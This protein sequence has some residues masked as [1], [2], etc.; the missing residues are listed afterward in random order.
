[1][2]C[3]III[4]KTGLCS[5]VKRGALKET[6]NGKVLEE[7]L[8]LGSIEGSLPRLQEAGSQE[9]VILSP[10]KGVGWQQHKADVITWIII[11]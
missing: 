11:R 6:V 7:S 8:I 9:K 10:G 3:K 2:Y 1:M 5:F 4:R